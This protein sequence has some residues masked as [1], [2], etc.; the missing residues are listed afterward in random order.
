VLSHD[1][2][3]NFS[4]VLS[5]NVPNIS[6]SGICD[7]THPSSYKFTLNGNSIPFSFESINILRDEMQS[8][9]TKSVNEVS[10]S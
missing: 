1:A 8:N 2:H 5:V 7:H 4:K 10:N 3:V 6:G 9:L